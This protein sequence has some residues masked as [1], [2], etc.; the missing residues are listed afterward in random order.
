MKKKKKIKVIRKAGKYK[1]GGL[2]GLSKMVQ[3]R[4]LITINHIYDNDKKLNL[5]N[6][7]FP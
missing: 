2:T 4:I 3:Y 5:N 7:N 6:L 1:S